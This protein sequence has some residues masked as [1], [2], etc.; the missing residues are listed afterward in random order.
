MTCTHSGG[1]LQLLIHREGA[2]RSHCLC[3]GTEAPAQDVSLPVSAGQAAARAV[4]YRQQRSFAR[5]AEGFRAAAEAGGDPRCHFAA[6]LCRLGVEWCG[7]EYHPTFFGRSLPW[8]PLDASEEWC[9]LSAVAEQL[10]PYAWQGLNEARAALEDVLGDVRREEGLAAC[11]VFLCYRRTPGNVS[12]ALRLCRDLKQ[13]GLRVFCADAS[14]RG[15]TQSQF[16]AAVYHALGTAEYLVLFPGDGAD[17]L[18]PWL[19]NELAR[20]ACPKENRFLC[21]DGHPHMPDIP[22]TALSLEEI[23][24]RLSAACTPESLRDQALAALQE[25]GSLPRALALLQ[26]ASAHGDQEARLLLATLWAEGTLVPADAARAAHYRRLAATPDEA[27]RQRVFAALDAAEDALHI[28]RRRALVYVAADV[29]DAGLAASRALLLPLLSA[30]QADRRLASAEVALVGYDRHARLIA[31]PQS[32]ASYGAAENAVRQLHTLSEGSR[33]RSAFAAK[34]LRL[35]ADQLLSTP[36]DGRATAIVLLSAAAS[37]DGP[38]A[39]G[40]ARAAIAGALP[41]AFTCTLHSPAQ[42]ADCIAGLL[43][44]IG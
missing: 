20:A 35:C 38:C 8:T 43:R 5:A 42:L 21:T 16:E 4:L 14:L 33:N 37:S 13:Q 34:G 3:C 44:A 12:A 26:R 41:Y 29:S 15:K 39:V 9:A 2:W 10:P 31:P 11:D 19:H 28:A 25:P 22:G 36:A 18:T 32:L 30:M 23:R 1:G 7:N 17:A 40:A 27:C 24:S 6:L